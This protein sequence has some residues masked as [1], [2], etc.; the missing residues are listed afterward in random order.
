M[1]SL[2]LVPECCSL[3]SSPKP[4]Q[5]CC[6]HEISL[7]PAATLSSRRARLFVRLASTSSFS[8][9]HTTKNNGRMFCRCFFVKYEN[10]IISQR[11]CGT[12][13]QT[14]SA[15]TMYLHRCKCSMSYRVHTHYH[16]CRHT[17]VWRAT[18][19]QH[20]GRHLHCHCSCNIYDFGNKTIEPLSG[21]ESVYPC[22]LPLWEVGLCRYDNL[23]QVVPIVNICKPIFG[24]SISSNLPWDT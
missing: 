5:W 2:T 17:D 3:A 16:S 7:N 8:G 15:K 11:R 14:S 21:Y 10:F 13:Y 19:H 22:A 20:R 1:A 24:L 23:C 12:D 6:S 4:R 9:L 18:Y